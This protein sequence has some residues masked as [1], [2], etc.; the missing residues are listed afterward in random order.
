[1]TR[2][3]QSHRASE[4]TPLTPL[5]GRHVLKQILEHQPSESDTTVDAR[6][7]FM[8]TDNTN[9]VISVHLTNFSPG[10]RTIGGLG[11]GTGTNLPNAELQAVPSQRITLYEVKNALQLARRACVVGVH[12]AGPFI[13]VV[14][15]QDE[16]GVTLAGWKTE[17]KNIV[18]LDNVTGFGQGKIMFERVVKIP[19]RKI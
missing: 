8:P 5:I 10:A 2:T 15:F 4:N 1:M 19:E 6:I 11:Q 3:S 9:F 12:T 14:W 18:D 17:L 13:A 16:K 7:D